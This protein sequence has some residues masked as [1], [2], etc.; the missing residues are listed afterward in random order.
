VEPSGEEES[1]KCQ[2]EEE[3]DKAGRYMK[4]T[5]EQTRRKIKWK[6]RKKEQ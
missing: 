3:S 2:A 1:Q 6:S 4:I 5:E